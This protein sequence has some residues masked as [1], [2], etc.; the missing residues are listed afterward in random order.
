MHDWAALKTARD[1]YVQK[2][3]GIYESS[4]GKSK[5]QLVR[6]WA[7]LTDAHTVQVDGQTLR[8]ER[9]LIATGGRPQ[10][11]DIPGAALAIDSDGFFELTSRPERVTVIGGGYIGVEIAG[12]LAALGSAGSRWCCAGLRCCAASIRC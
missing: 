6:G 7:R 5:V 11:P 4:L 2:L 3:N 9:V 8:G 12:V 10:R 1:A